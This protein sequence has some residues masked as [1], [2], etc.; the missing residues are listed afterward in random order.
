MRDYAKSEF[1]KVVGMTQEHYD[2]IIKTKHK[3][4][5][6]GK[7][8]EIIAFYKECQDGNTSEKNDYFYKL[9][10]RKGWEEKSKDSL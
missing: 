5:I 10:P 3:K 1:K 8:R 2:Y 6:A 4:S 9:N 7:L